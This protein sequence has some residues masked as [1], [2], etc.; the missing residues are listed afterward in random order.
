MFFF[1]LNFDNFLG[2]KLEI[3]IWEK[4]ENKMTQ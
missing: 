4:L 2:E 1:H 3:F